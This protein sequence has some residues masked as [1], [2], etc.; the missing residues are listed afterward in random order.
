MAYCVD[1][2]NFYYSDAENHDGDKTVMPQS[3]TQL[4]KTANIKIGRTHTTIF[5]HR[6]VRS[7]F[8]GGLFISIMYIT[9]DSDLSNQELHLFEKRGISFEMAIEECARELEHDVGVLEDIIWYKNIPKFMRTTGMTVTRSKCEDFSKS[10]PGRKIAEMY[11][12]KIRSCE[13]WSE[14]YDAICFENQFQKDM[15]K[16]M[17]SEMGQQQCRKV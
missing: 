14:L 12:E 1:F 11:I 13:N 16:T 15:R 5:N 3:L 9:D 2:V 7:M 4:P 6:V 17:I 8:S 10:A